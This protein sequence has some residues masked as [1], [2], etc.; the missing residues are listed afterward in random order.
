MLTSMPCSLCTARAR[1]QTCA[2]PADTQQKLVESDDPLT[3][4]REAIRT[5][6]ISQKMV[7]DKQ[8]ST[9]QASNAA[10]KQALSGAA[11]RASQMQR[12]RLLQGASTPGAMPSPGSE[13]AALRTSQGITE[14][15][16]LSSSLHAAIVSPL[17]S[18][19]DA[20]GSLSIECLLHSSKYV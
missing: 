18:C 8:L 20:T 11:T 12:Q 7:F 19:T 17:L 5:S 15:A 6:L 3:T 1:A 10:A 13:N 4:C 9:I 2:E 14:G 16:H